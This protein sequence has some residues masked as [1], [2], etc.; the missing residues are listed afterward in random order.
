MV[1]IIAI[2]MQSVVLGITFSVG[3]MPLVSRAIAGEMQR[4]KG[5]PFV[6]AA[7][8]CG[9]SKIDSA[10]RH[11]IP[12][13]APVLVPLLVQ[14]SGAG[15]AADGVFGLIGFGNRTALNI[16]TLLLRGKENSLL[17]PHLLVV[18]VFA[19]GLLFCYLWQLGFY[20]FCGKTD[21]FYKAFS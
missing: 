6:E 21:N 9:A 18:A 14:L 8:L 3:T 20:A 1:L 7:R 4:L 12:N 15:A 5:M 13:A 10:I 2:P 16:G 19:V 11:I 17:H